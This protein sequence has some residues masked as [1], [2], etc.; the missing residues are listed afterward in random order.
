MMLLVFR[1]MLGNWRLSLGIIIAVAGL[2]FSY[3]LGASR[4]NQAWED[5]IQS[6][7]QKAQ[8][9]AD[10]HAI[11]Y[12]TEHAKDQAELLKIREELA[13]EKNTNPAYAACH[14]GPGFL[15]AYDAAAGR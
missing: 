12:E 10:G 15:R 8:D 4:A 6:A 1:W 14:A 11:D 3:H 2:G 9:S 13:H 5:R 7:R